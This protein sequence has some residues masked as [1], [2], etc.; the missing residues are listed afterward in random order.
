[1]RVDYGAGLRIYYGKKGLNIVI[2]LVGG[3]KGGQDRDI[4]RAKRYW[5][6]YKESEHENE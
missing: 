5:L 1:M 3:D 2:L 4:A 6:A